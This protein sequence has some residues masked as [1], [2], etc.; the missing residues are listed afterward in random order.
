MVGFDPARVSIQIDIRTREV[1]CQ[2]RCLQPSPLASTQ[3]VV[4]PALP[5]T[6]HLMEHFGKFASYNEDDPDL[7]RM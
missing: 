5:Q 3:H 4:T 6:V 1:E 7:N 2:C